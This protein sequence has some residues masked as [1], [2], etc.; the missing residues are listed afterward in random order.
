MIHEPSLLVVGPDNRIVTVLDSH[1]MLPE[2]SLLGHPLSVAGLKLTPDQAK[3]GI[4]LHDPQQLTES[5]L[6]SVTLEVGQA[7][8]VHSARVRR[9][10]LSPSASGAGQLLMLYPSDEHKSE[11]LVQNVSAMI[12][13]LL[14]NRHDCNL[15]PLDFLRRLTETFGANH[16]WIWRLATRSTLMDVTPRAEVMGAHYPHHAVS[17]STDP[18]AWLGMAQRAL[19]QEKKVSCFRGPAPHADRPGT[20]ADYLCVRLHVFDSAGWL[21]IM[22]RG[23]NDRPWAP[24]E[25]EA[26]ESTHLK[27]SLLFE[28]IFINIRNTQTNLYL[29]NLLR[30]ADIGVLFISHR[31]GREVVELV[32]DQFCHLFRVNRAD[33]N[34]KGPQKVGELFS[35]QLGNKPYEEGL[36]KQLLDHPELQHTDEVFLK[37]GERVLRRFSTPAYDRLGAIIG[38]M[39][40]FRDITHDK[41]MESQLVHSQKMESIGTLAGGVAHDFNNLLTTMLGYAE[42]SRSELEPEHPV[43]EKLQQIEKAARRAAEL[44]R[45]LLAFSRRTPTMLQVLNLSLLVRDTAAMIRLGIPSIVEVTY[46][47]DDALPC[48]E[49]DETQIQQVIMNLLFNARDALLDEKGKILVTTRSFI[50]KSDGENSPSEYVVIDVEDSG[51]GIPSDDLHRIFEPFYTTK[52]VGKGTGLGLSMVYGIIKQHGGFIEVSTAPGD[53]SVFSIFLPATKKP[54]PEVLKPPVSIVREEGVEEGRREVRILVVDDEKELAEFSAL[55]LSRT[56][57]EVVVA[58]DGV[59][60]LSLFKANANFDLVL[61]DLTMPRM[62]GVE[63]FQELRKL[64]PTL[65]IVVCSGYSV[66]AGAKDL[67][68]QPGTAFLQKPF[69]ADELLL[70]VGKTLDQKR[71]RSP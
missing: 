46:K 47:L 22:E 4:P 41:E 59:E 54:M 19:E 2:A 70:I 63:C 17:Y 3:E 36:L 25:I 8:T 10:P 45:N 55:T 50:S 31:E 30:A 37:A 51:T 6:Y 39:F 12:N 61:L 24:S 18:A 57:K 69:M 48:V 43:G 16:A 1:E 11:A 32:N 44:T 35:E 71:L 9:V 14:S 53:G 23:Q 65:P 21:L 66:E 5:K 27:L 67:I 56:C 20:M 64:D 42:L 68:S 28:G 29:E 34:R 15:G 33:I 40:F 38:R 60:A 49:A 58:H 26:L 62:G 13:E 52:E 7:R